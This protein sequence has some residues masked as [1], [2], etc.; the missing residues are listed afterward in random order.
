MNTPYPSRKRLPHIPPM[1]RHNAPI[2]L[3]VTVCMRNRQHMLANEAS[4]NALLQTWREV[5]NW[6]VGDYMIMPDHAHFFCVPGEIHPPN[7]QQWTKYW[8]RVAGRKHE[9]FKNNWQ[10]DCWDTQIRD[11][12]HYNEKLAYVRMNP[13]RKGLV[14]EPDAWPYQGRIFEIVR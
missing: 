13:A 4:C 3:F 7:I 14:T 1:E 11:L 10:D 12:D 6:R 2:V 8:K 5:T 9:R